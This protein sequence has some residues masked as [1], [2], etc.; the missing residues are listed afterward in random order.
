[1]K[2]TSN[3][4]LSVLGAI[5]V[6]AIAGNALA[7]EYI[8]ES[9]SDGKN[10]DKYSDVNC[11]NSSV[12]SSAAGC[13]S[14]IGCRYS[15]NVAAQATYTFTPNQS[16]MWSVHVTWPRSTNGDTAVLH[17]VT[18]AGGTYA[19]NL[20]Q[21]QDAGGANV[22][23]HIGDFQFNAGETY[24]V[25]QTNPT[26][27]GPAGATT[28]LMADAVKF[29][30]LFPN[31]GDTP[32]VGVA[33]PLLI[34]DTQVTVTGVSQQATE[35]KVYAFDGV[36]SQVIGTKNAPGSGNVAVPVTP[37]VAGQNINA[38]QTV[39]GIE[40]C[41]LTNGPVPGCGSVPTVSIAGILVAGDTTVQVT[42]VHPNATQVS[43]FSN[44]IQIGVNSTLPGGGA[45]PGTVSVSVAAI[46]DG[47]SIAAKQTIS[48]CESALGPA[49]VVDCAQVP[50][51]KV[52]GLV[53][54]GRTKVRV[55]G[56]SADATAVK[57]YANDILIGVNNA[58]NAGTT[59]NVVVTTSPLVEG[60]IVKAVQF[61]RR[62][63]CM[64]TT[65]RRVMA[66]N[67]LEDFE[68][69]TAADIPNQ[70]PVTGGEFRKWYNI[71]NYGLCVTTPTVS[72][73]LGS[74][75]IRFEDNGWTNGMYALYEQVI[76][77]DGLYHL[78]VDMLPDEV[79]KGDPTWLN[80][81]QV[82]VIVNGQHRTPDTRLAYVTSPIGS[83]PC[84]TPGVDGAD[85]DQPVVVYVATFSANEG[86]NLLI[87][88]S[89]DTSSYTRNL[90]NTGPFCGMWI[91]NIR[92]IPGEKP[93][94]CT[95]VASP[96]IL[97]TA[98]TPLEAGRTEVS[99]TGVD[100][101]ASEVRVYANGELIGTSGGGASQIAVAVPPLQPG[102]RLTASQVV[103]GVESC[104][105]PGATGLVVGTGQNSPV[106]VTLGIRETGQ[107]SGTIGA[108]GGT[109]GAIEWVGAS[110]TIGGAPQGK[111]LP[112]DTRWQTVTFASAKAGG[113]DPVLS[114]NAG[115]G[116]LDGNWGTLEHIAITID[117]PYNTG[118]YVLLIDS[119]YNGDTPVCNF[120]DPSTFTP[121][122]LAM[123]RA[124]NYSGSTS[125]NLMA[126]PSFA[127]V[128]ASQGAD[129][130][131]QSYRF[132]F[133]FVDDMPKRWV[134]LT[135]DGSADA[136]LANPLI[137]LTKPVTI[138]FLLYGQ[139]M[140]GEVFA[141][142]DGDG[143]VDM[144]DFAVFQRCLTLNGTAGV[145]EDCV[146]F[147]R[148]FDGVI[149]ADDL[150]S[151]E[152]CASGANVPA[153]PDCDD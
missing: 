135:T 74:K 114:Y 13:T 87:V 23:N 127:G 15:T 40:S 132:E 95:D 55:A 17:T 14:G 115:N 134:R 3:R 152:K 9:R 10:F 123:F 86:D 62:D 56:V 58:P 82:G 68:D 143:D 46:Q 57:V 44:G 93:P 49:K 59:G 98:A 130:S 145:T 60:Q 126:Y 6:L 109:T 149:N 97:P 116:V 99:V 153:D 65:G 35:V 138:K 78:R 70:P 81:F 36:S 33:T 118:R 27:E 104:A 31:C 112:T 16:G 32:P 121:G 72:S 47:A 91:D 122:A 28:R 111:P 1:M 146:C 5:L 94:V 106:K 43:V 7:Y 64:P 151:F 142:A 26:H 84:L 8:I 85:A 141:D 54:A 88:F 102:W 45:T 150:A 140:C 92:L 76:P 80:Q 119:I 129:G 37:L 22:W 52:V 69:L 136:E 34:G 18:Y 25:V 19:V 107:A 139:P 144:A 147:D 77:E 12:K 120:D 48:V 2:R 100:P 61:I 117:E 67:M 131:A 71:A 53:D 101:A 42:G 83:Y 79:G 148:P 125:M 113:T 51:V 103:N 50:E 73:L 96:S 21:H 39:N 20:N 38:T 29:T 90:T 133:Q 63:G 89:T 75:C 11:D 108:N 24:T 110:E 4:S 105:C 124:P 66:A 30:S 41:L 137:D 128:D